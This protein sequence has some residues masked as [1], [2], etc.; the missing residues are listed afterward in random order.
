MQVF[1]VTFAKFLGTPFFYITPLLA[2]SISTLTIESMSKT[3][4]NKEKNDYYSDIS[5]KME[6]FFVY[7]LVYMKLHVY[8]THT[9]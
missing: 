5:S 9:H 2:A 8:Q 1:P 4:L 6:S 3:F 7:N